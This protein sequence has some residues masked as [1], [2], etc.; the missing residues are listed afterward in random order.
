MPTTGTRRRTSSCCFGLLTTARRS[1]T[2]AALFDDLCP[3]CGRPSWRTTQRRSCL[4]GE[5]RTGAADSRQLVANRNRR[6]HD[7][8][9]ARVRYQARLHGPA[10]PRCGRVVHRNDDGSFSVIEEPGIEGGLARKTGWRRCSVA[11]CTKKS[12]TG[13]LSPTGSTCRLCRQTRLETE[14]TAIG[15]G[16]TR[17]FRVGF[18]S[19]STS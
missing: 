2:T 13:S 10:P 7:R 4:V 3:Y 8:E 17:P 19:G 16:R 6:D 11:I 5:T 9:H 18:H 14:L 12:D 1:R 15:R